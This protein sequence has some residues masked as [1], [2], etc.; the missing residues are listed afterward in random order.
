MDGNE[1]VWGVAYYQGTRIVTAII[2]GE[3]YWEG[4]V[5]ASILVKGKY[6]YSDANRF[7]APSQR[8]SLRAG[9]LVIDGA[10]IYEGTRARAARR[11]FLSAAG[12]REVLSARP[13]PQFQNWLHQQAPDDFEAVEVPVEENAFSALQEAQRALA[14]SRL[15]PGQV[16]MLAV[17]VR[18]ALECL[19]RACDDLRDALEGRPSAYDP[20]EPQPES[21][22]S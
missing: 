12:V 10:Q 13:N 1:I 11:T 8:R 20:P 22:G 4:T 9:H 17:Q 5:I 21:S 6:P 15:L 7:T 18:T 2:D 3:R 14:E 16:A 19:R